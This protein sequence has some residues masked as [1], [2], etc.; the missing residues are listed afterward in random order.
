MVREEAQI[1]LYLSLKA[2]K[3]RCDLWLTCQRAILPILVK[4]TDSTEEQANRK[5]C[6]GGIFHR[7]I[8]YYTLIVSR[9]N[10]FIL[11]RNPDPYVNILSFYEYCTRNNNKRSI[12]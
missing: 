12:K 3:L 2:V 6:V 5:R 11:N 9:A 8:S 1:L 4:C 7:A 10:S